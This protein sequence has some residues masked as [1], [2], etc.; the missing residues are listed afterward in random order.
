MW[1]TPRCNE[2]YDAK[3]QTTLPV[4][5]DAGGSHAVAGDCQHRG[6]GGGGGLAGGGEGAGEDGRH[7]GDQQ[8]AGK[9]HGADEGAADGDLARMAEYIGADDIHLQDDY[10]NDTAV[11]IIYVVRNLIGVRHHGWNAM[12]N[13]YS[14]SQ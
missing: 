3:I 7:H 4:W 6:G 8:Y 14:N 5:P 10:G 11:T 1:A 2:A 12:D 13:H 9:C